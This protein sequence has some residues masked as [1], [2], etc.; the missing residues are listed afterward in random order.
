MDSLIL[1]VLR[2]KR[3]YSTLLHAV[4]KEM[5]AGE[6]QTMLAW[7]SAYWVAYPDAQ[8]IELDALL[9][10]IKLRSGTASAEQVAITLHIASSLANEPDA[11][12]MDGVVNQLT[13]LD[14]AGRAG[15]LISRYNSGDEVD[16]S[17]ELQAMCMETR[18]GQQAGGVSTWAD[19]PIHE[20]LEA[21]SD[22]GGLQW[23]MFP[24]LAQNLKG[25]RP[26]D[27]VGIAAPTDKGK[28]SLLCLTAIAMQAQAKEI[29]PGRPLLY[30]VNEGTAERI[31]PRMYQTATGMSR[32]EMYA[33]SNAGLLIPKYEKIV[34]PVGSIR[35]KNIHGKNMSQVEQIIQHHNPHT[36][37]TDMT[38]RIK[39]VSNR[40]GGAND[41]NQ[42]EEVW[43]GMREMAVIHNFGHI[44]TIQVSAEGFEQ[45]YPP[46]SAMQNS[47]TGIQTTLDLI[48]MMG[49]IST[50]PNL[51]GLH[52]PKNKLARSGKDSL[53]QFQAVFSPG[54]NKWDTGAA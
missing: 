26:G 23:S 20:Y 36:V 40:G 10:L 22:T 46:I 14:L 30:L 25:L 4:P 27:N 8:R 39:A 32:D 12:L 47:K 1:H 54:T 33:A 19:R 43:N 45:I 35:I 49:A 48:I 6:T 13:E 37:I 7:Y 41:I 9:A 28:T 50:H 17:F 15:A 53:N 3:R 21:D 52:T 34:G 44:G 51:R 2:D 5:L 18:R 42:L 31:T 29:Y 16:L 38:G 11:S 24:Q